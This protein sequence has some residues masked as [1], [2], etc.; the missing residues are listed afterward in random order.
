M[1]ALLSTRKP[2]EQRDKKRAEGS[3]KG[4]SAT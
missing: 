4:K 1:L 3:G 2:R